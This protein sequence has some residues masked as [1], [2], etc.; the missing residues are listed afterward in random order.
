MRQMMAEEKFKGTYS[1]LFSK[2][3]LIQEWLN[4]KLEQRQKATAEDDKDNYEA[5]K[6]NTTSEKTLSFDVW[7]E[8]KTQ[9]QKQL[10]RILR[11]I[12]SCR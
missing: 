2:E 1:Y 3:T 5:H 7:L 6:R 10:Q 12:K 8:K 4:K 11:Q 9:Q